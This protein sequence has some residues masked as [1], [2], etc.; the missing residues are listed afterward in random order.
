MNLE[1]QKI[2][3]ENYRF[4]FLKVSV[5]E[6]DLWLDNHTRFKSLVV[7]NEFEI[8][9]LNWQDVC[10]TFVNHLQK[11]HP[12]PSQRLLEAPAFIIRDKLFVSNPRTGYVETDFGLYIK[13]FTDSKKV[14]E[15]IKRLIQIYYLNPNDVYI[16]VEV[17]PKFLG[18][19][20]K[21]WIDQ[22]RQKLKDFIFNTFKDDE[23]TYEIVLGALD[24][25]NNVLNKSSTSS[26]N[27]V[28]LLNSH[29]DYETYSHKALNHWRLSNKYTPTQ[30][31][32][33][34]E[35]L[36]VARFYKGDIYRREQIEKPKLIIEDGE[37][38]IPLA[39]TSHFYDE[40]LNKND[41]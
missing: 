22:E 2:K 28:Y 30:Y 12:A 25:L 14:L 9:N 6:S 41:E 21:I 31:E 15:A 38:I 11:V 37:R 4:Y 23:K 7:Y 35:Y 33:A 10:V 8:A 27:D 39:S 34:V 13:R 18:E 36:E 19:D 3:N 32:K 40:A 26:Y 16:V 5:G 17:P 1:L 20:K 24:A 29:K